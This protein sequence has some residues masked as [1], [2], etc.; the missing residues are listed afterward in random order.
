MPKIE[1]FSPFGIYF[2]RDVLN[3]GLRQLIM[4]E[5][6]AAKT[7]TTGQV[8]G[9][10]GEG[11]DH[12]DWRKVRVTAL[13]VPLQQ[14]IDAKLSALQPRLESHFGQSL[15]GHE[16]FQCLVYQPGD[17]YRY[18]QDV[19]PKESMEHSAKGRKVSLVLFVNGEGE[20]TEQEYRGG[21]LM[22][23]GL[24][25][26]KSGKNFGIPVQP[27]TSMAVVFPSETFHEVALVLEG[28]RITI[29]T[30]YF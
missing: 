25:Q 21:A 16:R 13:S 9:K 14:E 15:K 17:F 30:F 18:H 11:L 24:V 22:F 3:N 7:F 12:E 5:V 26:G 28:Q 19:L 2:E 6:R 20:N 10:Q 8:I 27:E 23:Y 4:D 1:F 29:V